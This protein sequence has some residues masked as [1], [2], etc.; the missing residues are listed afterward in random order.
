M[1]RMASIDLAIKNEQAEMEFYLEHAKHAANPI[2]RVLFHTLA[3]DERE[4]MTRIRV[5]HEKLITDGSWPADVPIEVAGTNIQRVLAEATRVSRV[6]N[7]HEADDI[8][9]LKHGAEFEAR[10]AKF[11]ADLAAAC[12]NPQ[13]QKFFKFLSG[14]EREHLLSIKDSIFYLEDPEGWLESHERQGLDGG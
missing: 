5:L 10:G 13:E 12:D 3:Q 14:I 6:T 8:E 1:D 4:H 11:Y 9:A 2:A 7:I